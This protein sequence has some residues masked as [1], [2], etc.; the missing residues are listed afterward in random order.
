MPTE[1]NDILR[2]A[3]RLSIA[4]V[5]DFVNVFHYRQTGATPVS[6]QDTLED[7]GIAMDDIYT[8]LA[9]RQ[10]VTVTYEDVNAFN[11]TQ[12]RPLGTIDW[13]VLTS[14]GSGT[15]PLPAQVAAFVRGTTGY[16]RNWARKFFG[17]FNEQ[18]ST[19]NGFIASAL[20]TALGD[21]AANWISGPLSGWIGQYVPVVLD[22]DAGQ[23]RQV[24]EA[25]ISNVWA[26]VRRRRA[27]R[28]A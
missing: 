1:Q 23:W 7:M 17:P 26:T 4:D 14:G 8:P 18:D 28:G 22:A 27:G 5:G 2:V 19:G 20:L 25:I 6:D 24:I 15:D 16:S 9:A 13:P 10:A 12:G 21:A 11:V 3:A